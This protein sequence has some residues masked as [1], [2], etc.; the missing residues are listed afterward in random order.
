MKKM[1]I[2]TLCFIVLSSNIYSQEKG[3]NMLREG[4]VKPISYLIN[5]VEQIDSIAN[6]IVEIDARYVSYFGHYD[7]IITM[8]YF[9]DTNFEDFGKRNIYEFRVPSEKV[10]EKK[11]VINDV[12]IWNRNLGKGETGNISINID[13]KVVTMEIAY[14]DGKFIKIIWENRQFQRLFLKVGEGWTYWFKDYKKCDWNLHIIPSK[15]F[16]VEQPK[17]IVKVSKDDPPVGIPGN[18]ITYIIPD[19]GVDF[20]FLAK[21]IG[22]YKVVFE[23]KNSNEQRIFEAIVE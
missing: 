3:R 1:L 10:I 5:G 20:W 17:S 19:D 7:Y 4:F 22:K 2:L 15:G 14:S 8:N 21:K 18:Q 16:S 23:N 9:H 11:L 12:S 13:N 6:M